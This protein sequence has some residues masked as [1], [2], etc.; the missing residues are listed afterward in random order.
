[1]ISEHVRKIADDVLE[2]LFWECS[3]NGVYEYEIYADYRDEM[4]NTQAIEILESD[5]PELALNEWLLDVYGDEESEI[6]YQIIKKIA[7]RVERSSLCDQQDIWDYLLDKI[8]FV[9]PYKHFM[10]QEFNTNIVVD[11]GDGNYDF[12]LN[13]TFPS[14]YGRED[15]IVDDKASIVWLAE[16]QGY[17]K[18]QLWEALLKGDISDPKGF[19]Q[20]MRQE[21][22]NISSGCNAL[23]FLVK[24]TLEELIKL[25][26]LIKAQSRNGRFYDATKNPDCG[27]ICLGKETETGLYD[28]WNGSGSVFEIQL[29]YEVNLPIRFIHSAL[30]DS[31]NKYSVS[32]VYG[33]SAA[34]R[35]TVKS[36]SV[37]DELKDE[38]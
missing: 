2:D 19:L 22:I 32:S 25:N 26:R 3:K 6:R 27:I 7:E 5:D 12:V 36:I 21:V 37:P 4:D 16:E 9:Y 15:E 24:T 30:P 18:K 11:T 33:M 23:T 14:W 17:T 38:F 35:R 20:S 28:A 1:M 34:W 10:A 31:G 8:E 29:E 13:S